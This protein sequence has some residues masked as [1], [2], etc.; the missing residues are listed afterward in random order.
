MP[1]AWRLAGEVRHG[2]THFELHLTL[3]AATVPRV[4]ADGFLCDAGSLD[5]EALPSL[6]RKCVAAVYVDGASTRRSIR[7]SRATASSR[8]TDTGE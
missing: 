1:A 2:F 4:E 6:M 5:G 3:Y 7:S 8:R